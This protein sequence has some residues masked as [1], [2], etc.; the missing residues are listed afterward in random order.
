MPKG[1]ELRLKA[2]LKWLSN[3]LTSPRASGKLSNNS[4]QSSIDYDDDMESFVAID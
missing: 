3:C 1:K 2:F 4:V